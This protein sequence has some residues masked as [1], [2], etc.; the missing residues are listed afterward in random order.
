MAPPVSLLAELSR[1]YYS[2]MAVARNV[3]RTGTLPLVSIIGA[4]AIVSLSYYLYRKKRTQWQQA[5]EEKGHE[6]LH[7]I[8]AHFRE[9]HLDPETTVEEANKRRTT[10]YY[11]KARAAHLN[12]LVSG[13]GSYSL[14][15]KLRAQE[16]DNI[17]R[18]YNEGTKSH[19]TVVVSKI[20]C[21][22][23]REENW[24]STR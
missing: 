24:L 18:Y 3:N 22:C 5:E 17:L 12:V 1:Q 6:A 9:L 19:R 21:V 10:S 7:S 4:T 15:Q 14:L 20:E 23:V 11:E 13:V 2:T 8:I 16:M